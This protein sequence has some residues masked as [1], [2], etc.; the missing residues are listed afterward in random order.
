MNIN[1]Y[2]FDKTIYNGD[3][4][5]DFYFYCVKESPKTLFYLPS[6]I[7]GFLMYIIGYYSKVRFKEKFYS[8]LIS[9]DDVDN[10]VISFWKVSKNKIQNWYISNDHSKDVII[11]ASPE[12]LLKPLCDSLNVKLLIASRVNKNNGK[13]EGENCY[14]KEKVY[15]LKDEM[16]EYSIDQFYSDSLS[17][18]PLAEI[19]NRSFIV[20]REKIINWH[21]YKPSRFKRFIFMFN[22]IEFK[23]FLLIGLV[24]TFNGI[25]F[26][27]LYS[28]ILDKNLG[29]ILGYITSLS[30]SYLLN[31]FITFKETL[32]FKKY[33]K[34]CIS[35]VPN[36]II[37]NII[38]LIFL[39]YLG[40]YKL[41]V[42]ILAATIGMPVTFL[43]IKFYTFRRQYGEI[44]SLTKCK[45]GRSEI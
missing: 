15:R 34:F 35:Y 12:F 19:A 28:L 9:L 8:F 40:W 2:D 25:L 21:D 36:F 33:L 39:N 29:F 3:S 16:K 32:G 30:I 17:D 1:V 18:S 5:L 11:S 13:Y 22:S 43:L 6:Q 4:T 10:M 42:Y 14:G 44:N 7:F 38:V 23:I 41:L 37:Q 27:Y 31:S 20:D 45:K 26:A 24:N